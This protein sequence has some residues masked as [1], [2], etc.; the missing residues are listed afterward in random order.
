[1][2]IGQRAESSPYRKILLLFDRVSEQSCGRGAVYAYFYKLS[3]AIILLVKN[4]N[5]ILAG[6]AEQL[7]ARTFGETFDQNSNTLP[8][9]RLLLFRKLV[10]QVDHACKRRTFFFTDRI[11]KML[12]RIG[13]RTLG[14]FEKKAL[15]SHFMHQGKRFWIILL[16]F[17]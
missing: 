8:I 15:P 11:G 1:M 6:T 16:R 3:Y 17:E 5:L 12:G 13:S 10:L 4:H 9:S 7:F 2:A 14:I